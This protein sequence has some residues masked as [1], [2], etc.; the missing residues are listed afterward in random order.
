MWAIRAYNEKSNLVKQVREV[1]S[2]EMTFE[3]RFKYE[4]TLIKRREFKLREQ[5]V[6]RPCGKTE[7]DVYEGLKEG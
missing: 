6:E 3:L 1:F 5:P 2:K 7:D 4:Q